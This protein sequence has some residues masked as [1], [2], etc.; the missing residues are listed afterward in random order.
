MRTLKSIVWGVLRESRI[1]FGDDYISPGELYHKALLNGYKGKQSDLIER[2]ELMAKKREI[3]G[4]VRGRAQRMWFRH[5]TSSRSY[6]E[7]FS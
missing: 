7:Q 6:Q 5:L 4:R 3:D 2:A 1:I